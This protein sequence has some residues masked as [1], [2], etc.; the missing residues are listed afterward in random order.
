MGYIE[1]QKKIALQY[2]YENR[3][4]VLK[5]AAEYYQKNKARIS[6]YNHEYYMRRKLK[7]LQDEI[8]EHKN[9]AKT[10]KKKEFNK[11]HVSLSNSSINFLTLSFSESDETLTDYEPPKNTKKA[12]VKPK[13]KTKR[14]KINISF[15]SSIDPL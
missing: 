4:K 6:N 13:R 8:N 3:E 14:P 15:N 2:Y 1:N 10:P 9:L 5:R 11:I 7:K 12:N